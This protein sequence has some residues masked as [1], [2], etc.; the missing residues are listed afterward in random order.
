MKR[1]WLVIGGII[2]FILIIF[3]W[4]RNSYNRFVI[5][6]EGIR[7][8]LGQLNN[9]YQQRLDLI[10]NLVSTV[11][12]SVAAERQTLE[13]VVSARSRASSIT[14]TPEALKDPQA[15]ANFQQAQDGLSSAI[16]R[17]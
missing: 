11:Q 10:P 15:F 14:L 2:L 1:S 12:G 17:L 7:A 5:K 16:S 13:A 9:V 3:F 8:Q 6:E 4:W